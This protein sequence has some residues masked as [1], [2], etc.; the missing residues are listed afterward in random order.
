VLSR[1]D[2]SAT[3]RSRFLREAK[4]A[5][6]LNHPNIVTIYEYDSVD[7]LDFIAMEFIPGTTLHQMLAQGSTPLDSLLEFARQVASALARAH[8]AGIIHRDMKPNNIM[9]TEGIAKVLDFGLAKRE[10]S[11]PADVDATETQALTRVGAIVGTPAYMSPEQAM[12]EPADYRSDIFSFGIILYEMACGRRPFQGSNPQATLHQ[13]ASVDPLAVSEVNR[14]APRDLARLIERCLKKKK[15]E[16]LQS[17]A[18]VAAELAAMVQPRAPATASSRRRML[19]AGVLVA[20]G[21]AAGVWYSRKPAPS[22]ERGLI[23]SL[24]AQQLRDGQPVGEPHMVSAGEA[25]Q[26]GWR[27]RLRAQSPQPGYLYLIDEGP[28]Q[29]GGEQLV[30]LYPVTA[31][32]PLPPNR[33][34]LTPWYRIEGAPGTERLWIVWAKEPVSELEGS[35]HSGTG[36]AVVEPDLTG[37]VR[38]LLAALGS[39]RQSSEG[40]SVGTIQLR[41]SASV[42]GAR[43][44]LHHQ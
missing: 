13:I 19:A 15:E 39:A 32:T 6:A 4:A 2:G 20:A 11:V 5:S 7:S 41:G 16:R 8:A 26:G 24:E 29:A 3:D 12:G 22:R 37:K 10:T 21:L 38:A 40:E 28:D 23:C 14:S 27:F 25:F 18:A 34:A 1:P 44:E 31:G 30:V 42:L 35:I 33:P 9:V 17:M 43:L 36:G